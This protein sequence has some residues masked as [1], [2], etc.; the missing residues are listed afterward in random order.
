MIIDRVHVKYRD[1]FVCSRIIYLHIRKDS[2]K[3][4]LNNDEKNID[5]NYCDPYLSGSKAHSMVL[6]E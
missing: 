5:E 2:M 1:E 6:I 4:L 3:Y